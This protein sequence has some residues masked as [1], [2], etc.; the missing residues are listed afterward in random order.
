LQEVSVLLPPDLPGLAPVLEDAAWHAGVRAGP[1]REL[2]DQ[3]DAA[4]LTGLTWPDLAT[5]D[6]VAGLRTI[7][8]TLAAVILGIGLLTFAMAAIDRA[9]VSRREVVALQVI[10]SSPVIP[11]T[12]P[13]ARSRAPDGAR[14]PPGD[15]LRTPGGATYLD[16][17]GD[18]TPAPV[19]VRQTATLA[20][21]AVA[22]SLAIAGLTV[23]ATNSRIAPDQI[24][25]E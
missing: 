14:L 2:V 11:V 5:Y 20:G 9:L 13:V 19:P 10:G 21:I 12:G 3:L 24:R 4:G 15:R 7:V 23:I 25:A 8:W 6:F 17:V 22:C 1:G 16:L 18:E